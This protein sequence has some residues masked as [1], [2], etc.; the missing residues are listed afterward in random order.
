[1]DLHMKVPA[2]K[3]MKVPALP[4][5]CSDITDEMVESENAVICL[6]PALCS[7]ITDRGSGGPH[8]RRQSSRGRPRLP[9]HV[10]THP[11]PATL[12]GNLGTC[13]EHFFVTASVTFP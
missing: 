8:A 1:M 13:L 4:A 3:L 10:A 6:P 11:H 9:Q 7:D 2:M 5:L 12:R